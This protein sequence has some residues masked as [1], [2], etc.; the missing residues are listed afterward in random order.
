MV[1]FK[2]WKTKS[3]IFVISLV[4]LFLLGKAQEPQVHPEVP[5][6][7]TP[8]EVVET[9]LEMLEIDENDVLY[10]LGCGDGRIVVTAAKKYGCRG[11]GI[12]IDPQRILESRENAAKEGVE[13]RVEFIQMDLFKADLSQATAV[14]LYLLTEVN[15]RLRP[16]LLQELNP[17]T[18]VVSHD[19]DMGKWIADRE[20]FL[21]DYWEVHTVY[22]WTIPAN[23]SGTW[24]WTFPDNG[25]SEEFSLKLEQKFQ[26]LAGKVRV[27]Q[28]E[29]PVSIEA[30]K[31]Q[32]NKLRFSFERKARGDVQRLSF[33]GI[34][35][36]HTLEGIM[37]IEGTGRTERW[38]ARRNPSTVR[39]IDDSEKGSFNLE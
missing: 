3:L 26:T 24:I 38:T 33:E 32:G 6:V 5:F 7:P 36:G 4:F 18:P 39:P 23:V 19:F 11:V 1:L 17:G 9:M 10:D 31:I 37:K 35:V 14:T 16:K 29:Y 22:L 28:V 21:E 2:S 20:T 34:V 30:G 12:D 13:D 25:K 15:L 27:G 8:E